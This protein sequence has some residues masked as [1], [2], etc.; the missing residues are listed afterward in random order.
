MSAIG[1]IYNFDKAP[2]CRDD[3]W[4]LSA[5]LS[6]YGPD[7]GGE[8]L[9][10]HVGMVQRAFHTNLESAQ[11]VQPYCLEGIAL[12]W[13]GRLDNREELLR[14][15]FS[16][17]EGLTDVQIVLSAYKRWGTDSPKYIQGDFA[18]SLW[19]SKL[20]KLLLARDPMG[21][22]PLYYQQTNRGVFWSSELAA[23][24]VRA[25]YEAEIND[26]F[27]WGY[28]TS[29]PRAYLTPYKN[30]HA[31]DP[32]TTIIFEGNRSSRSIFWRLPEQILNYKTDQ[33]YEE[34]F[35]ELFKN[36]VRNRLRINGPAW[37]TLSGGLDSSAIV[38]VADLVQRTESISASEI[39][40]LSYVYDEAVGSD[41]RSFINCVEKHC[42]R[43]S[44]HLHDTDHRP[45][46][47]F[48]NDEIAFPDFL[49]CF[50]DR[51][52]ALSKAMS[53]N[54]AR[55]LLTG[56]GGDQLLSAGE[57][58][59]PGIADKLSRGLLSEAHRDLQ[60]W[61]ETLQVPYLKLLLESASYLLPKGIGV[62]GQS[63][64][65]HAPWIKTKRRMVYEDERCTFKLPS[66]RDQAAWLFSIVNALS[67]T[68]YHTRGHI[69]V[70]HPFLDRRLCEFLQSL[71]FEQRVRKGESRSLVRRALRN[72]LPEKILKRRGKR[73]PDESIL[74]AIDREWAK[75]EPIFSDAHI[76]SR[77]YVDRDAFQEA[78]VR[79]RH[80]C[81]KH[82]FSLIKTLSLEFWL[83][84][85][86]GQM[87]R[88]KSEA[89][90][91]G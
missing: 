60:T 39:A 43:V 84:A 87:S 11:E 68:S 85:L 16:S 62:F 18:L 83:R 49:D 88:A 41:E 86:A 67:R 66:Q 46:D 56:H 58:P 33:D 79:A 82:T 90:P 28:L 13:D 57:I 4:L 14:D 45:L 20:N 31:V 38:C 24:L 1:G 37:V 54:G 70:S 25:N 2:V 10:G 75:L 64:R 63:Q 15:L 5:Q 36:S 29:E 53:E 12:C 47:S 61:S 7:G 44:Y 21:P 32:G 65:K 81:E 74:R 52:L 72:I 23:L 80:G 71:P 6:A 22:R 17:Q 27:V 89:L 9:A 42:G 50:V 3:L 19:D 34:H 76:Y 91:N 55:V 48:P 69:E 26:D 73:G 8:M 51:H 40:T 77:G 59:S 35:L 78:L 30:F